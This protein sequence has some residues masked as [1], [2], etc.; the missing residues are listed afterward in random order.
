MSALE[1]ARALVRRADGVADADTTEN[2]LPNETNENNE[3]IA[4]PPRAEGL[5]S[6]HSFNSSCQTP[7]REDRGERAGLIEFGANVPRQWAVGYAALCS[8]VPP[9]GFSPERWQRIIDAAGSFLDRWAAK[10]VACGSSDLD[11]FGCD[12]DRPDARFDCMGLVMLLDRM[13]VVGI[14]PEGDDL[15][16]PAGGAKVRFRRRPL[17]QH[18]ISL[19][20]LNRP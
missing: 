17:P 2:S 15:I 11:V 6:F 1:L 20:D 10:A 19:W 12:P 5:I 18:T 13:G 7:E 14:D 16:A 8:M 3:L 4:P 9:Q